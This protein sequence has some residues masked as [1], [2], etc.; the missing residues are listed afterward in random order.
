MKLVHCSIS[1]E[2]SLES[3]KVQEAVRLGMSDQLITLLLLTR[4]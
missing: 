4:E 2:A 1:L 3:A